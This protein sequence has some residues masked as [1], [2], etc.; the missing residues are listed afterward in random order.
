MSGRGGLDTAAVGNLAK[1]MGTIR[2]GC[3]RMVRVADRQDH[4]QD[5]PAKE[6]GTKAPAQRHRQMNRIDV[7]SD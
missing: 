4:A 7:S 3:S 2:L 6:T 1:R 5:E